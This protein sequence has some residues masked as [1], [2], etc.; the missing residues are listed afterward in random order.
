MREIELGEI[1]EKRLEAVQRIMLKKRSIFIQ[2]NPLWEDELMPK[3]IVALFIQMIQSFTSAH[4]AIS[5]RDK[6]SKIMILNQ[7]NYLKL[8]EKQ[9]CPVCETDLPTDN[10]Y[11]R[12][13][14]FKIEE[15]EKVL[16]TVKEKSEMRMELCFIKIDEE[17]VIKLMDTIKKILETNLFQISFKEEKVLIPIN[18]RC[19]EDN[20]KKIKIVITIEKKKQCKNCK[21]WNHSRSDFC[22]E[23]G[24]PLPFR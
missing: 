24:S 3:E 16:E 17:I 9:R 8:R 13:C 14:N 18:Y 2:G 20:P 11:C 7:K 21:A 4:I 1:N 5:L 10:N 23:C 6:Y 19:P 15:T 22:L 12:I